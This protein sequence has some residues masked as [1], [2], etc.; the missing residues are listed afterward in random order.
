VNLTVVNIPKLGALAFWVPLAKL[1]TYRKYTLFGTGFF[2]IAAG[3]TYTGIKA[4]FGNGI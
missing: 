2:L 1:I 4:V 3:T